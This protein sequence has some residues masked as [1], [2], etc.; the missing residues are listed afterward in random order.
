[1]AG[2]LNSVLTKLLFSARQQSGRDGD[3]LNFT[4]VDRVEIDLQVGITCERK[5]AAGLQTTRCGLQVNPLDLKEAIVSLQHGFAG[6][7]RSITARFNGRGCELRTDRPDV[8]LKSVPGKLTSILPVAL[9]AN[10]TAVCD[11]N[12]SGAATSSP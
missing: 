7:R 12:M 4:R 5:L 11:N 1:M 8:L 2:D 10:G 6:D 3:A 9:P